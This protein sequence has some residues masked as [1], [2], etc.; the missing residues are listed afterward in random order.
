MSKHVD[1]FIAPPV[2]ADDEEDG[3]IVD[4]PQADN[5]KS[6]SNFTFR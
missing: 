2:M 3:E 4:E 5:N 6:K 1:L